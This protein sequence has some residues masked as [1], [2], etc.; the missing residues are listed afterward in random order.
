MRDDGIV[1]NNDPYQGHSPSTSERCT[2]TNGIHRA[3]T[4]TKL[5]HWNAQEAITKTSVI[6]TA[7]VLDDSDDTRHTIQTQTG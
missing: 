4:H 3:V 5:V 1:I 7:I 6:K 2:I